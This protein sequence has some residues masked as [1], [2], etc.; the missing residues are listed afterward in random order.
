MSSKET[1]E[2]ASVI[3]FVSAICGVS[4]LALV[5]F[6]VV[7]A[8]GRAWAHLE[9]HLRMEPGLAPALVLVMGALLIGGGLYGRS[10]RPSA[11]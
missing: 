4:G 1:S 5:V 9:T 10:R 8:A 11:E 7:H 2:N 3:R 6:A